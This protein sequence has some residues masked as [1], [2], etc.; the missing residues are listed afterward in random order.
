MALTTATQFSLL[1]G[2]RST[3]VANFGPNGCK[4][5]IVIVAGI[6]VTGCLNFVCEQLLE[7]CPSPASYCPAL[8]TM[9]PNA[10]MGGS[11]LL[12]SED[13]AAYRTTL[14]TAPGIVPHRQRVAMD[15]SPTSFA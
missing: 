6:T 10:A 9:S 5:G 15:A 7:P 1:R 3:L 14:P 8:R 13:Y 12:F 4:S 2:F 11:R